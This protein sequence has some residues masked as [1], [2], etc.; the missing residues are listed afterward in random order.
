MDSILCQLEN[1]YSAT[2]VILKTYTLKEGT[3]PEL[4]LYW[5]VQV[6]KWCIQ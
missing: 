6:K 3:V 5:G 2:K 1:K 4:D